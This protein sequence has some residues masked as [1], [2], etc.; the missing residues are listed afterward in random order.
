M[1]QN[2]L[3]DSQRRCKTA[4]SLHLRNRPCVFWFSTCWSWLLGKRNEERDSQLI[5]GERCRRTRENVS[6]RSVNIYLFALG[7]FKIVILS[8][9]DL[10][11]GQCF[12]MWDAS[13]PGSLVCSLSRLGAITAGRLD[14]LLFVKGEWHSHTVWMAKMLNDIYGMNLRRMRRELINLF[15]SFSWLPICYRPETSSDN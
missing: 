15:I 12:L 4:F 2:E 11:N 10:C 5:N 7:R 8:N 13:F 3:I 1:E 9:V 6:L 14:C